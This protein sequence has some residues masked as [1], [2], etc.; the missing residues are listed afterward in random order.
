MQ[1]NKHKFLPR[2]TLPKLSFNWGFIKTLQNF[3]YKH[4]VGLENVQTYFLKWEN[5]KDVELAQTKCQKN[6]IWTID[7]M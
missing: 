5:L 6:S 2:P 4:I 1:A 3:I 7:R